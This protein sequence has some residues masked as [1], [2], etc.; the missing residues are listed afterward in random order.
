MEKK[1]GKAGEK[2]YMSNANNR[3]RSRNPSSNNRIGGKD[4]DKRENKKEKIK[5]NQ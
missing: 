3:R 2:G 1:K 4:I 5:I